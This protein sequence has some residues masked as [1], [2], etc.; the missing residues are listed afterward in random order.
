MQFS[1]QSNAGTPISL[2]FRMLP[3]GQPLAVSRWGL[4]SSG[5]REIRSPTRSESDRDVSQNGYL[6]CGG[7]QARV[8][9]VKFALRGPAGQRGQ[10]APSSEPAHLRNWT[11]GKVPQ[12]SPS[13]FGDEP[14][15]T[16]FSPA[17]TDATPSRSSC[18]TSCG[19][20]GTSKE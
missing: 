11:H 6:S 19:S 12:Q 14:V 9:V 18:N 2:K 13:H 17:S 20:S 16:H 15:R 5:M 4:A 8:F 1:P 7:W 3:C 10:T